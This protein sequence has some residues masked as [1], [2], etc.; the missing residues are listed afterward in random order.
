M[1]KRIF[2]L[3]M[4]S[5]MCFLVGSRIWAA[6]E[7][8]FWS[9]YSQGDYNQ[10]ETIAKEL[11]IDNPAYYEFASICYQNTS[12]YE[13]F[14]IYDNKF[15]KLGSSDALKTL[16]TGQQTVTPDDPQWLLFQGLVEMVYPEVQ[17]GD[18]GV[19]LQKA[20][21]QLGDNPYLNNYLA[22]NEMNKHNYSAGV[23]KY[24]QKAIALKKDY[25][26]PY[27]NLAEALAQ[28][29]ETDK[30]IT[31]LLD[32]FTNCPRVPAKA[33]LNLIN[34]TSNSV[35]NTI[36]PY[37]QSMMVAVPNM[38]EVYRSKIKT[39]L[40][41]TPDHLNNFA[42]I[43]AMKG[44]TELARYFIDG[45]ISTESNVPIYLQLQI[46]NFE[47]NF[48]QVIQISKSLLNTN[49]LNY[50]R[51]YETG[52]VLFYGKEFKSAITFY[53]EAL[54]KIN[55]DD[56][57]F[58]IKIYTNLGICSYLTQE[59]QSALGYFEKVL[60]ISPHDVNSLIYSGLSYKD[61][62]DK[63]KALENLTKALEYIPDTD[64][65]Q[66]ITNIISQLK[67]EDTASSELK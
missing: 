37:G 58:L 24:L 27:I 49:D 67:P 14:R 66:E 62:G 11:S 52:N 47:G 51:L 28:N 18:P 64:W 13:Q 20:A 44:N 45:E 26:E 60:A 12:D 1:G 34:L 55:A 9:A 50:Q 25:P 32:C 4:V 21:V 33:Y 10:A 36:R 59:Y 5:V 19:L 2:L 46:A 41:K 31:V 6:N 40:S 56:D 8:D 53:Q 17:L 57:E 16:L 35:T 23:Q 3:L 29:K 22:L 63:T 42:E 15:K 30:A 38:K 48:E 65:R 43:L 61:L 39:S 7:N 54:K